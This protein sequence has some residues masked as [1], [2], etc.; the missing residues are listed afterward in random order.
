MISAEKIKEKLTI[1]DIISLAT[2][3]QGSDEYYY[4]TQGHPIFNT[5]LDH[6]TGNAWKIY[7]YDETKLFHCYTG[8]AESYDVFELV[9]RARG[10]NFKEAYSYIVNFFHL[11]NDQKGFVDNSEPPVLDE[12]DIFQ[13]VEDYAKKAQPAEVCSSVAE[14][15][16][17]YFYPLAAPTEWSKEGISADVMY[18]YGIRID[19]ALSKIIIPHRNINGELIGIRGRAFDPIELLDGKK[20]MPVYIEGK[21][22]NHSLGKNLFGLYENKETIKRVKKVLVC[23][24]EKSVLQAASFYGLDDCFAVATCGSSFSK[25]QINLLLNL[26]VEEVIM[27]L[28]REF[29]GGKGA[30]DTLAY[31]E[32]ILKL[33]GS[34]LPYVNVSVIMDYDHLLPYK[35][36][37]TDCGKEIFETLYHNRVKL[38]TE[39]KNLTPKNKRRY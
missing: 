34:L 23:E 10:C 2:A 5:M 29:Q 15:L 36:S 7:Y 27:G 22:Y 20:Y 9:C 17:E 28:D 21:L 30:P 8:T 13:K 18:H 37:P 4:D 25:E 12:W 14:N 19:S 11:N 32:K 26:G 39:T 1:N 24:G 31:E 6:C 3:L 33:V 16:L 35:G 38:Y